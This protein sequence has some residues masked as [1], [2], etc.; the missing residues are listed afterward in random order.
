MA[1]IHTQPGQVDYTA[2]VFVVHKDKV[3]LRMHDKYR[4]WLAVGGHIELDEDPTQAAVREV[5]EEVGLEVELAGHV[6]EYGGE[7]DGY[8]EL[9]APRYMNIHDISDTHRHLSLVYFARSN[10]DDVRPSGAD[11]SNEWKWLSRGELEK[12]ELGIKNSIRFYALEALREL[13]E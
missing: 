10:S 8:I 1:H 11:V 2:D 4:M 3:L 6:P 13:G 7:K 9:I 5:K 12:N